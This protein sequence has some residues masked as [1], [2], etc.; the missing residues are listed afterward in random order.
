[1][2]A[3]DRAGRLAGTVN[4]PYGL[5]AERSTKSGLADGPGPVTASPPT[6]CGMGMCLC[7]GSVD[8][9]AWRLR[10]ALGD[11]QARSMT[12]P[13]WKQSAAQKV[14]WLLGQDP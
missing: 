12:L 13:A 7:S 6:L 8:Y 4:D 9:A 14:G 2:A 10:T 3:E 5:E 11:W 1:M